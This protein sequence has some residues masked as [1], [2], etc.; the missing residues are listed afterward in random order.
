MKTTLHKIKITGPVYELHSNS[1]QID[2]HLHYACRIDPISDRYY[3]FIVYNIQMQMF[4]IVLKDNWEIENIMKFFKYTDKSPS[5]KIIN[6]FKYI[7]NKCINLTSHNEK[8][9]KIEI[10]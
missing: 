10:V 9:H 8:Y 7:N 5:T 4:L 1:Q 6:K 3:S 2:I